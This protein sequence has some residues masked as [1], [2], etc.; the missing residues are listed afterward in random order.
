M[1][2]RSFCS[3][4]WT[5]QFLVGRHKSILT[6]RSF[7]VDNSASGAVYTGLAVT[8]NATGNFLFAADIVNNKVDMY[9]SNFM[10]VKSFTDPSVPRDLLLLAFRTSMDWCT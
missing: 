7:Q 3:L 8:S 9:D 10:W 2:L 6:S 4:H 1:I 5:E